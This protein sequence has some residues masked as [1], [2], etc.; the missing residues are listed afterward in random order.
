MNLRDLEYLVALQELKH[1]R[2]AAEKCFVSQPTLSGQ[3][4][5]LEDE[6]D[7]ILIERTSR[8]V[9]FT[10]A[11]EKIAEQ[12]RTVL[13]ES[14]AIKEIA[15][16]YANPTSGAIH[17]GLIPTVAPYLLPLIVP[18]LKQEFPDLDMFLHEN[19]THVLLKQLDEGE[20]DCL[21]L[22]YLPGMEKYGR[23]DL[24]DEPLEL[25]IPSSHRWAGRGNVDLA[26]LKGEHILMLE[27][28]HCLRDQ[29][30]DYCF[31]AGAEEDQSFKATS[32]ETLRH[33]IAAEGG[34]TLLP[35]L[36]I[37]RSR[38]TDGVEYIKFTAP[39][40]IRRIALLYR[41]GSVRRP[42]FNDVAAVINKRVSAILSK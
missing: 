21:L 18:P 4:R 10:P 20:L 22:A 29:A 27:D 42:C 25:I 14:K 41:K 7:I 15:K 2:K 39:E 37:P 34:V 13:L 26:E 6:L 8:K 19:Q 35:H 40:P 28:G 23:I 31:T 38:F 24:Y 17:I 5:K 33:M 12:A 11:G 32:L 1:F 3:I 30:M 16:S 36:A 9:L